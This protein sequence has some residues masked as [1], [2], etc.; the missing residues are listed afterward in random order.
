MGYQFCTDALYS[1]SPS[2]TMDD[3]IDAQDQQI[4][5]FSEDVVF[6]TPD[7]RQ[8]SE[9]RGLSEMLLDIKDIFI[10]QINNFVASDEG[11]T[12]PELTTKLNEVNNMIQNPTCENMAIIS[13]NLP[14]N[15]EKCT[16]SD[17][18]KS[19]T[20]YLGYEDDSI[21]AVS[22]FKNQVIQKYNCTKI[23]Q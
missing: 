4:N 15:F 18:N 11:P 13:P 17:S 14:S 19:I 12:L 21:E 1:V 7:F 9:V 10:D 5:S 3:L 22:K 2:V 8:Y 20:M 23:L 6:D 16:F